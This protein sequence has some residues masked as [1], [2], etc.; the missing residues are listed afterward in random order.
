M[1]TKI[2]PKRGFWKAKW[3]LKLKWPLQKMPI[4]VLSGM[5]SVVL[6]RMQQQSKHCLA[7]K[8]PRQDYR[9]REG[10]L[11]E[12]CGCTQGIQ[13]N[14]GPGEERSQDSPAL[15]PSPGNQWFS[16]SVN[17][18]GIPLSDTDRIFHAL[19]W[20]SPGEF[21]FVSKSENHQNGCFALFLKEYELYL[22]SRIGGNER[23]PKEVRGCHHRVT[24]KA[25]KPQ[26]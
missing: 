21:W 7:F 2:L 26:E 14:E 15:P 6:W 4:P 20:G 23:L 24:H 19:A 22:K 5:A 18:S 1:T 13:Q 11:L 9:F 8:L 3:A 25:R 16:A 17:F 12:V 10:L